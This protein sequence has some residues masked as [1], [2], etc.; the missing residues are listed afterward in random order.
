MQSIKIGACFSF[1]FD[2]I[3]NLSGWR[4]LACLLIPPG[5]ETSS[6]TLS[7]LAVYLHLCN[8]ICVLHPLLCRKIRV[9]RGDLREV[10]DPW[11]KDCDRYHYT[12][13]HP[14]RRGRRGEQVKIE[15][16]PPARRELTERQ[17]GQKK[18]TLKGWKEHRHRKGKNNKRRGKK[19]ADKRTKER[20]RSFQ[21]DATIQKKKMKQ[22]KQKK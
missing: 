10:Q 20:K 16:L 6:Q 14:H 17:M 15:Y 22:Q 2:S 5:S 4:L 8:I 3:A 9:S 1:I 11:E 19:E 12:S 7:L 13:Q 21:V 18:R